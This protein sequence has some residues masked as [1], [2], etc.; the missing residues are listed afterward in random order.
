MTDCIINI[1]SGKAFIQF[2]QVIG[3][4]VVLVFSEIKSLLK[5]QEIRNT[6]SIKFALPDSRGKISIHI[7]FGQN[8]IVKKINVASNHN[9]RYG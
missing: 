5:S 8:E 1:V 9:I 4:G 7:F 6:N 2:D 3:N